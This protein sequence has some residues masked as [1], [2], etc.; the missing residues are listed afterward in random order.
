MCSSDLSSAVTLPAPHAG[1]LRGLAVPAGVTLVVGGG[2]HGKSTLLDALAHGVYDHI[3][4]DGRERCVTEPTA[5]VIRAEDG[6]PVRGVDLRP[7]INHLPLGR[8][9]ERFD[10]D[11]ASGSTSQ[12]ANIVEALE[13][14]ARTLLIDEDTAAT[15]LDR[16][17]VV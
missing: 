3:P 11:D 13:A 5:V 15:M 16:K 12:A 10:T 1:A 8:S 4:G 17:S 6:R 7:F 2:Y 9:T 14:G